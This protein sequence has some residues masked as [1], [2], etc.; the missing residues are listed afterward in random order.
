[1]W[2]YLISS[3]ELFS[4]RKS[5]SL[6]VD[7]TRNLWLLL[8]FKDLEIKSKTIIYEVNN[9]PRQRKSTVHPQRKM[10][11][12]HKNTAELLDY[13]VTKS[14]DIRQLEIEFTNGWKI[15]QR[16]SIQF[17]FYTNSTSERDGL[18]DKLLSISGQGPIETLSLE[19]NFSYFFRGH[20]ELVKIDIDG[21]PS[22]DEFWPVE[23]V[24]A[25]RE[26]IRKAE[27]EEE[28][29]LEN[30]TELVDQSDHVSFVSTMNISKEFLGIK[31]EGWT[32]EDPF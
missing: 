19:P 3:I 23:E 20:N 26:A 18:I 31:L 13:L 14:Y 32:E 15:K 21:I 17:C 25:W 9:G 12:K 10:Q 5:F 24:S 7:T 27:K 11:K 28:L 16:P 6:W 8:H 1:M 30:T 4:N 29:K 2:T 22:P